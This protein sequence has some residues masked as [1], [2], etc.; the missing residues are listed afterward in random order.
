MIFIFLTAK[1][2]N[3]WN[4]PLLISKTSILYHNISFMKITVIPLSILKILRKIQ[5]TILSLKIQQDFSIQMIPMIIT[6][7][8]TKIR[9]MMIHSI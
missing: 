6:N 8:K 2:Q 9:V 5:N 1:L 4:W 7:P 3:A